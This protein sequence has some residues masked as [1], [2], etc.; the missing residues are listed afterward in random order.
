M[1]PMSTV[2]QYHHLLQVHAWKFMAPSP[3]PGDL[4]P[5]CQSPASFILR[6]PPMGILHHQPRHPRGLPVCFLRRYMNTPVQA[7]LLVNLS[8]GY[9][10][11]ETGSSANGLWASKG[12]GS[13]E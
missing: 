3:G 6:P 11:S 12:M 9:A 1:Y 7:P 13:A 2:Q 8:R 10:S 4:S 5:A